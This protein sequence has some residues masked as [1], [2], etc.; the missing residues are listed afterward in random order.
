MD[1]GNIRAKNDEIICSESVPT[2]T[3]LIESISENLDIFTR[4]LQNNLVHDDIFE[5]KFL[6]SKEVIKAGTKKFQNLTGGLGV[7]T[8]ETGKNLIHQFRTK[9]GPLKGSKND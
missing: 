5:S 8:I 3:I 1:I 2:E 9:N 6:G 4:K 7:Q